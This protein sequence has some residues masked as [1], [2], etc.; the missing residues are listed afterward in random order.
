[1]VVVVEC[2]ASDG[3]AREALRAGV[4]GAVRRTAGVEGEVVLA[5]PRSLTFTTS[6]KLSRAAVR[7]DYLSGTIRDVVGP[8]DAVPAVA[9]A[10]NLVEPRWRAAS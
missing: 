4:A 3:S 9:V 8:G 7:T 2:R 10:A 6:G 1:M 5:P